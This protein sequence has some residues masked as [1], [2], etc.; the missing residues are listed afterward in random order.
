MA[1][2]NRRVRRQATVTLFVVV[3]DSVAA[4]RSDG[5]VGN[6]AETRVDS[7]RQR[8]RQSRLGT[9]RP[10]PTPSSSST[11]THTHTHHQR[12]WARFTKYLT[13][14][15]LLHYDNAEV[16]IHKTSYE[17]RKG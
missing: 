16:S 9:L 6:V 10:L 3:D 15:L 8:L 11:H 1:C 17:G 2:T 12:P 7:S 13:T 5:R 14:T 4:M